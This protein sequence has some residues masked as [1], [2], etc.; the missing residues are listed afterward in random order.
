MVQPA[1]GLGLL[2]LTATGVRQGRPQLANDVAGAFSAGM[3]GT[4]C[5]QQ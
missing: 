5:V 1:E 4:W 2:G 3:G